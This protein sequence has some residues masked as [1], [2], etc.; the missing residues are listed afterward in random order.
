MSGW[1]RLR[2]ESSDYNGLYQ[3]TSRLDCLVQVSTG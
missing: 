3:V 2:N 1:V